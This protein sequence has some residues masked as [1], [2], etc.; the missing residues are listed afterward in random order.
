MT[1]S[2]MRN[3]MR[4]LLAL[5]IITLCYWVYFSLPEATHITAVALFQI[6]P[7]L[8]IAPIFIQCRSPH[9]HIALPVI[10]I[11]M[12]FT[13]PNLFLDGTAQVIALIE[14]ALNIALSSSIM[15]Y[16]LKASKLQRQLN[17]DQVLH[18]ERTPS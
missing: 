11:Y 7:L 4:L 15:W 5:F 18:H 10:M 13:A 8:L 16:L 9:L 12:C 14:L 3:I 6:F 1:L 2:V 17:Q